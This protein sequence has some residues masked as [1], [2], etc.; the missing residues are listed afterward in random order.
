MDRSPEFYRRLIRL[1]LDLE[2]VRTVLC[3]LLLALLWVLDVPWWLNVSLPFV[4]YAG[5]R[6]LGPAKE[7]ALPAPDGARP[8]P[9]EQEAY[10]RC[11]R[12]RAEITVLGQQVR[13][14]ENAK[15]IRA[16]DERFGQILAVIGEDAKYSMSVSLCGLIGTTHE[17]LARYVK[18]VR[19]HLDEE[20]DHVRVHDNLITINHSCDQLWRQVNRDTV[21][22]L[23]AMIETINATLKQLDPPTEE[24]PGSIPPVPP[25]SSAPPPISPSLDDLPTDAE[26]PEPLA[27]R[28]VAAPANEWELPSPDDVDEPPALPSGPTTPASANGTGPEAGL[29]PRELEVLCL[30]VDGR[31]NQQIASDLFISEGTTKRHVN[32]IL[33]KLNVSS[34]LAAAAYASKRDLCRTSPSRR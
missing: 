1:A 8:L 21:I 9:G 33:T 2:A 34:R 4:A 31:S 10:E 11:Q 18:K 23:E 13:D 15:Q 20:A 27:D 26:L 5:L 22:D 25:V 14:E 3:L 17:L 29:T 30:L 16:I 24:P 6:L 32:S 7:P 28:T 19:R 12:L